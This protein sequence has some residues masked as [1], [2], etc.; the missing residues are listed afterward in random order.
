MR[1]GTFTRLAD[2]EAP[3]TLAWPERDRLVT[4]PRSLP[5]TVRNVVLPGCGHLPTW[6]DPELVADVLLDGSRE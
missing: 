2:V 6:D 3:V 4:R 1:A 5:P